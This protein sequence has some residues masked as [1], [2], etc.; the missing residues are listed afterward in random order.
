RLADG[1]A[2]CWLRQTDECSG[3]ILATTPFPVGRWNTVPPPQAQEAIRQCMSRYG[4][5]GVLRVD[6]GHPWGKPGGQPPALALLPGG[7]GGLGIGLHVNDPHCPQQ[8]GVMESGNGVS[9]RWVN[10]GGCTDF[11]V[12][13]RRLQEEDVNQRE[14]YPALNGRSRWEAYIGLRRSGRGY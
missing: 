11:A 1:S 14:R 12:F 9:Q 13:S 5:P 7:L 8:N 6:N 10:P 3:A 4:C 2:A